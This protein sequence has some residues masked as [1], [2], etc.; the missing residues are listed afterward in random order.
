MYQEEIKFFSK[1]QKKV[2]NNVFC[3][4]MFDFRKIKNLSR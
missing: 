1:G 2:F 4:Q 3:K